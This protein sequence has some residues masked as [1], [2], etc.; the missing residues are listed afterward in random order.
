MYYDVINV[1]HHINMQKLKF[2]DLSRPSPTFAY[3]NYYVII[4]LC[5]TFYVLNLNQIWFRFVNYLL[6]FFYVLYVL[7]TK[8]VSNKILLKVIKNH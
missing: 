7:W 1:Y 3:V 4:T 5:P 8:T 2:L 6:S